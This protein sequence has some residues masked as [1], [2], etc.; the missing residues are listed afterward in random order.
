MPLLYKVDKIW[1]ASA[2]EDYWAYVVGYY[3]RF[4]RLKAADNYRLQ[5]WLRENIRSIKK[6]PL[7]SCFKDVENDIYLGH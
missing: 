1:G 7:E 5:K 6:Q 3:N 2:V 4:Y